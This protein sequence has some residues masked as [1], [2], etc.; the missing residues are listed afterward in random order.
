MIVRLLHTSNAHVETGDFGDPSCYHPSG[1]IRFSLSVLAGTLLASVVAAGVSFSVLVC[2]QRLDMK[3]GSPTTA[4]S[5]GYIWMRGWVH[6]RYNIES[7][8][9][10]TTFQLWLAQSLIVAIMM[11]TLW[12]NVILQD[13]LDLGELRIPEGRESGRG[14]GR[15]Y[16]VVLHSVKGNTNLN[17]YIENH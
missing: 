10:S 17:K 15:N 13:L 7:K 9:P 1:S 6:A 16:W 12:E 3:F 11:T 4:F 5:T 8:L 2:S 14:M